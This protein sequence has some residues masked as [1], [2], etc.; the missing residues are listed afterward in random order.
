M[1]GVYVFVQQARF[2]HGGRQAV[3]IFIDTLLYRHERGSSVMRC[4]GHDARF[5][6]NR[7]SVRNG[8]RCVV[9]RVSNI[10]HAY[11][12]LSRAYAAPFAKCYRIKKDH[13]P[14]NRRAET[15]SRERKEEEE[16]TVI[17]PICYSNPAIPPERI[18]FETGRE[19]PD[20]PN[21]PMMFLKITKRRGL[22]LAAAVRLE[23]LR[24]FLD[25]ATRVEPL[26]DIRLSWKR[27]ELI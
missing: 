10:T 18:A 27:R 19:L 11:C 2:P 8:L 7:V 23:V 17:S 12:V 6:Y 24:V 26:V 3:S 1:K 22:Y 20:T 4:R 25:R 13:E 9:T 14:E 5:I 16:E 21:D 15:R